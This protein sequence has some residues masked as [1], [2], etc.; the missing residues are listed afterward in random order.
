LVSVEDVLVSGVGVASFR[1]RLLGRLMR[2]LREESGLTLKYVAAY[3]G[4]D[5]G[6][7][8]R[9]EHGQSATTRE[10]MIGLLDVY[11]EHDPSRRERLLRVAEAAWRARSEVD[12]DGAVPDEAFADLLWLEAEATRIQYYA[13]TSIPE[14]LHTAEFAEHLASATLG[15]GTVRQQVDARVQLTVRRQQVLRRS[16]QVLLEVVL[17]ECALHHPPGDRQ[18][19]AGQL[20]HLIK[21]AGSPTIRLQIL[22]AA[23]VRPPQ[24]VGGFAVFTLREPYPPSVTHIE[25]L[26]GRL[27]L[28]NGPDTVHSQLF[29]QLRELALPAEAST[30]LIA[31]L[32]NQSH[33]AE[34]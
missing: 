22:P 20:D 32:L 13:V 14:L 6:L 5:V 33:T 34:R 23:A 28:D 1:A 19:W 15:A 4:A 24:I 30:A 17:D 21:L 25:Y 26:G 9:M 12:F 27:L 8:R 16:E 7:V 31:D 18:V 29:D 3:L 2:G 11:R 10:Q